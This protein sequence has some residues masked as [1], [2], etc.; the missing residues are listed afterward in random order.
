MQTGVLTVL[1]RTLPAGEV[2]I[3]GCLAG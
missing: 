3:L 2:N 1:L